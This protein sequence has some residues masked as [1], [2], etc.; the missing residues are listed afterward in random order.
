MTDGDAN[1]SMKIYERY[2]LSLFN[3]ATFAIFFVLFD[4]VLYIA[5]LL[6]SSSVVLILKPNF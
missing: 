1:V 4:T 5:V 3:L 2:N 6:F